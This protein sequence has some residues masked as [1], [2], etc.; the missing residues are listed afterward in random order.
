MKKVTSAFLMATIMMG[1]CI[2]SAK[3]QST[4]QDMKYTDM[5][6]NNP[7]AE[8]DIKTVRDYINTLVVAGEVDK[9]MSMLSSNY[10]GFGPGPNDSANLQKT[11]EIWKQ[12]I[13]QTKNRKA[14]FV[15]ET[16]N[17]K[18][19]DLSGHWVSTWGTYSFTQNGKDIKFPF[20][21]TAHVSNGKIDQDRIYYDQLYIIQA[22]G[23]TITPPSK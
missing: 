23:Y 3:S 15:A 22:L 8:S 18:S 9:A 11:T 4:S 19:G 14:D 5:I 2:N 13:T 12:N 1:F 10:V 17:V 16:F 21:Y 6:G 7:N 20:Q